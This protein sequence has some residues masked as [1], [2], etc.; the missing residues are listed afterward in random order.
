MQ[1]KLSCEPDTRWCCCCQRIWISQLRNR[2]PCWLFKQFHRIGKYW[3]LVWH[4]W[5]LD[6]TI[7]SVLSYLWIHSII[8]IKIKVDHWVVMTVY[9]ICIYHIVPAALL[10][11]RKLLS[12]L[13]ITYLQALV[14]VAQAQLPAGH[15]GL[16]GAPVLPTDQTPALRP[17]RVCAQHLHTALIAGS[18]TCDSDLCMAKVLGNHKAKRR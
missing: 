9:Y 15:H 4:W 1:V 7:T 13:L 6:D 8:T 18:S 14:S 2:H 11:C 5:L 12:V 10:C 3:C 16:C 17:V